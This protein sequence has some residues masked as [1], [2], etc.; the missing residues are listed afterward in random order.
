VLD[1]M[2][3]DL[4]VILH[5]VGSS[6]REIHAVGVP[7]LS[8]SEDIANVRLQFENGCVANVTASRV[9]P[10][11]MRKIRV[12]IEDAYVSLDYRN[13]TGEL[14]RKT[15]AGIVREDVPIEK[16]SRSPMSSARSFA[17]SRA[18]TGRLFLASMLRKRSS[19]LWRSPAACG[20]EL[21]EQSVLLIAG[22]VSGDMHAAG[23]VRAILGQNS[24]SSSSGSAGMRFAPRGWR[25]W[26]MPVIWRSWDSRK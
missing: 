23:L 18:A 11:R 6:V 25:L 2:I 24:M 19:W 7:V 15:Q 20:R 5:L 1:L 17:A 26:S 8:G 13:Q 10:E 4:E 9:S 22:E 21:R 3:H 16:A 12:F 14:Y